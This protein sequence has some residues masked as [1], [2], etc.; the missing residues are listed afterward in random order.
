MNVNVAVELLRTG[1]AGSVS[2][3]AR[4]LGVPRVTLID[5]AARKN[6]DLTAVG[7]QPPS[8]AEGSSNTTEAAKADGLRGFKSTDGTEKTRQFEGA[9]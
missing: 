4:M 1:K 8:K 7:L 9:S 3:A 5:H 6:I 2:E